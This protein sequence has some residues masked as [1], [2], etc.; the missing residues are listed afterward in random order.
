MP[1]PVVLTFK[2]SPEFDRWILG[3]MG[4]H[5]L[6]RSDFVRQCIR[7]AGPLVRECPALL[8]TDDKRISEI[9]PNVG[10]ILVILDK[11]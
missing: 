3:E 6:N 1:D 9:M 10:K 5:D 2:V 7:I 4:F 11:V 8:D